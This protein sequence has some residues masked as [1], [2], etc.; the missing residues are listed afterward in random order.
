MTYPIALSASVSAEIKELAL[1]FS[2]ELEILSGL[3]VRGRKLYDAFVKPFGDDSFSAVVSHT[4]R[5]TASFNYDE[6]SRL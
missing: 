6:S 1:R 3:R 5:S 2:K 4:D